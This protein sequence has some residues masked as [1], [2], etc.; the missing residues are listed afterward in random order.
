MNFEAAR[1]IADAVLYEGYILYPYRASSRKNQVRWQFGVLAPRAW[2]QA[3]GCE[4]S[5]MQ[6]ECVVESESGFNLDGKLRF[7]QVQRRTI[8]EVDAGHYRAVDSLE[9]DGEL[10]TSWDEAVEREVDFSQAFNCSDDQRVL[11][12]QFQGAREVEALLTRSGREVGRVVRERLPILGEIRIESEKVSGA[13]PSLTKLRL[14]VENLTPC[15]DTSAE[16]EAVMHSSIVGVHAL[17]ELGAGQFISMLDPPQFARTAIE[18]CSNVRSWPVMLGSPGER[19]MIL[20]SPIILY[21]Y[22]QIAP[23]SP[24]DLF[25]ATEIDEILTLRT[26]TL[27]D[28]E[29]RE[30]RASD[31]RAAAIIDRVE[32]MPQE[33]LDR[34]HGSIRYLREVTAQPAD[35][36]ASPPWWDPASDASVSPETDCVRIGDSEVSKGA[37]VLLRPGHRRADAQDMFLEGKTAR[38]EGVFFD[39]DNKEY[40]AVTLEDDPAADLHQSHGRFLYFYPDEV[41]PLAA[42]GEANP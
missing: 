36:A 29:K 5:W 17:L 23:E 2:S 8:E 33:M 7:L 4:Q 27:T 32:Q 30:A 6:T 13:A 31:P 3:G 41:E 12:F 38:V 40:L 39:V 26:M 16:R 25:D 35:D 14:R 1:K 10:W 21:D 24:G 28:D 19:R 37:R 20:S 18:S 9:A 42:G 15:E 34:L 22:P 11:S